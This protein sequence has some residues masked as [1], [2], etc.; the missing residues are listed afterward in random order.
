MAANEVTVSEGHD[1]GKKLF[2]HD[3]RKTILLL[4]HTFGTRAMYRTVT[5]TL[6]QTQL[7]VSKSP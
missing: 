4:K 3:E 2:V 1:Y 7:T 5:I 6:Y